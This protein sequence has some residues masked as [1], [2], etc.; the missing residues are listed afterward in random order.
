MTTHD[1]CSRPPRSPTIVG[2][3]VET[4]V[5]SSAAR[6]MPSISAAK[7]GTSLR[8]LTP[9]QPCAMQ[10]AEHGVRR[11]GCP[12]RAPAQ[13]QRA[14][15]ARHP[16]RRQLA[17]ELA[18]RLAALEQRD[19]RLGEDVAATAHGAAARPAS[20]APR[21]PATRRTAGAARRSA[22]PSSRRQ[23]ASACSASLDR[24]R[25]DRLDQRLARREVAVDRGAADAGGGGD[26]RHAGARVLGE[27]PRRDLDDP[28]DVAG[29]VGTEARGPTVAPKR[30]TDVLL[31]ESVSDVHRR[32][33]ATR[34][35]ARARACRCAPPSSGVPLPSSTGRDVD[36]QL[37]ERR[38]REVLLHRRRRR[39]G[40][41]SSLSPAASRARA[42]AASE[43]SVTKWN[44]VPPSI[45]SGSRAWWVSTNTGWPNGGLVAPPAARVGVVLPR[46]G[47][48]AVHLAAHDPGAERAS[49]TSAITSE[50]TFAL[51][52]LE[53]VLLAPGHRAERPLVHLLAAD[54]ERVLHRGVGAG[55]E[56][57]EGDREIW[58]RVCS[59]A[60]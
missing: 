13:Q 35:R 7:I 55:D 14:E 34:S 43:P 24:L 20:S 21:R 12:S 23:A 57:V 1:R 11:S 45:S 26:I 8:S 53:A 56:A 51:A 58:R 2:S 46:P 50:S 29:G 22:L 28:V 33:W 52:A 16:L 49:V 36:L 40:P 31:H 27:Q 17:G 59:W 19:Q 42:S 44:V 18:G 38:R 41:G 48:A 54:A 5:W 6:N 39:R 4:I 60:S 9:R 30:D 32:R 47:A 10:G 37:V 15:D 25:P 3:A